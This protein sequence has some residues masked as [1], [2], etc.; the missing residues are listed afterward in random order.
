MKVLF[1]GGTGRLS[2]DVATLALERGMEVWLCTRGSIA[3][4]RYIRPEFKM[5]YADVFSEHSLSDVTNNKKY[6]VI[7]DFLSYTAEQLKQK[8]KV[9]AGKFHQYIFISSTTAY[10]PEHTDEIITEEATRLGNADWTYGWQKYEAECL[11]REMFTN[12]E[13][14]YYTILRPSVTYGNTRIP[15]PIVPMDSLKEW[16]FMERIEQGKA[17]PIFDEGKTYASFA[18]TRDFA[19]GA[20]GLFLN[21][22]ARNTAVHIANDCSVTYLELL[23]TLSEVMNKPINMVN[24]RQEEIYSSMPEYKEILI[25]GKGKN[26]FYSNAKI[27]QLVPDFNNTI[28]LRDGIADMY[29]NYIRNP[30]LKILDNEWDIKIDDMLRNYGSD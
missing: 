17:I 15:Y 4:E 12:T 11:L 2:K 20:V 27:K 16:S 10:Y 28:S 14:A 9:L 8:L 1:L 22:K 3:R 23:S 19:I 5:I 13:D 26:R 21:D 24:V 30:E 25:G 29:E 18:H 7:I 6:D